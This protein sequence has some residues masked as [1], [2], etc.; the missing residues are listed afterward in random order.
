MKTYQIEILTG[1]EWRVGER[2]QGRDVNCIL[3]AYDRALDRL[4]AGEIR[5]VRVRLHVG[6]RDEVTSMEE[7]RR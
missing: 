3:D 2:A 1:D 6:E 5:G 4:D 7:V